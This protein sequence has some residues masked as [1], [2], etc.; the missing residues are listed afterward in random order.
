MSELDDEIQREITKSE[1]DPTPQGIGKF[2]I[3]TSAIVGVALLVMLFIFYF[4]HTPI[5]QK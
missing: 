5:I 2:V 4:Y 3:V 1:H